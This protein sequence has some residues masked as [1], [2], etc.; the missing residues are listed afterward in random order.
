MVTPSKLD[1]SERKAPK[2]RSGV[3]D[4]TE[5][6]RWR[7]M[8]GYP[9]EAPA[10]QKRAFGVAESVKSTTATS[11]STASEVKQQRAVIPGRSDLD[12]IPLEQLTTEEFQYLL[13][14]ARELRPEW[15]KVNKAAMAHDA[16]P[17][18]K[19]VPS[20]DEFLNVSISSAPQTQVHP[21]FYMVIEQ[22]KK[23]SRLKALHK[24]DAPAVKPKS[25]MVQTIKKVQAR[26]L[27][28]VNN[29]YAVGI[30]GFVAF[31]PGNESSAK[32]GKGNRNRPHEM[33]AAMANGS[34]RPMDVYVLRAT[35]DSQ[36]RPEIVV[37]V[38]DPMALRGSENTPSGSYRAYPNA[39][40]GL[41]SSEGVR[42][43]DSLLGDQV[44]NPSSKVDDRP[45]PTGSP[46][47]N[48]LFDLKKNQKM[49]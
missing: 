23:E 19:G 40:G 18:S 38:K 22:E 13:Q 35:H 30:Q 1:D 6:I 4:Y 10:L 26:Y 47:D 33:E 43:I 7:E 31:M 27:N 46:L 2:Y 8:F 48:I 25:S 45:K 5:I 37:S 20:W 29:G 36:G 42:M 21:P 32:F 49:N 9:T 12:R 14:K 44:N 41:K 24:Y 34:N 39:F 17:V 15:I 3:W 16:S 11:Q 28:P